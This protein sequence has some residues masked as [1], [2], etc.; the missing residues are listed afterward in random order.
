[1]AILRY[2]LEALT[3]TTDYLQIDI[4]EYVRKDVVGGGTGSKLIGQQGFG[5]NTLNRKAGNTRSGSLSRKSVKNNGT[6]LLQIPSDIKDG[7]RELRVSGR[8]STRN[9]KICMLSLSR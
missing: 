5:R 4:K 9:I 7:K 1:M 2:P 6:I 3:G 8:I